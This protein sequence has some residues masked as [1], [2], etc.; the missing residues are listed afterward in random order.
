MEITKLITNKFKTNLCALFITVPLTEETV[1]KNALLVSVLRRG[2][3]KLKTQ[4]DISKKLEEMY[5]AGFNCGVDKIGNYHILK[6]Y[7]ET[8]DNSYTLENENLLQDGV[9]LLIDIV[10]NP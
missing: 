9:N 7:L 6:F 10:F 2:T 4:E 3:Q 8:I 5:G 1:T